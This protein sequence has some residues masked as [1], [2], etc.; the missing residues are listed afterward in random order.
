MA[1]TILMQA[2]QWI[3]YPTSCQ[4]HLVLYEDASKACICKAAHGALDIEGIAVAGVAI[5]DDGDRSGC[6][7]D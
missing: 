3:M 4:A 7:V 1:S 2:D 6:L 5:A